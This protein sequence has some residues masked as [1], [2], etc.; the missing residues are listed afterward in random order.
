MGWIHRGRLEHDD[1]A[2]IFALAPGGVSDPV[3]TLYGYAIYRVEEKK[4]AK[5]LA[6]EEVNKTRLAEELRRAEIARVRAEWLAD[7]RQRAKVEVIPV[8]P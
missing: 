3:R 4:P 6:W 5:A 1:D 2:A 7:L 8:E